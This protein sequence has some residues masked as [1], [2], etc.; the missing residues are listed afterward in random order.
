M[1]RLLTTVMV[2]ALLVVT[3]ATAAERI[4]LPDNYSIGYTF[5]GYVK[6]ADGWH[7][8][9]GVY[10]LV[11]YKE[12]I[13][14][15]YGYK[16]HWQIFYDFK[17][18]RAL[19]KL[20]YK[21]PTWRTQ[22]VELLRDQ[23][24]ANAFERAIGVLGVQFPSSSYYQKT[25]HYPTQFRK[26][27]VDLISTV[28]IDVLNQQIFKNIEGMQLTQAQASTERKEMFTQLLQLQAMRDMREGYER[29]LRAGQPAVSVEQG[30]IG[31]APIRALRG[32]V[33]PELLAIDKKYNCTGCHAKSNS[34]KWTPQLHM[35]LDNLGQKEVI[36]RL[37]SKGKDH[38]PR[39]TEKDE[40]APDLSTD[41]ILKFLVP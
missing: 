33:S 21:D 10:S 9:N 31:P 30:A 24:E 32:V 20:D 4:Y 11:E 12:W 3:S 16:G 41:E 13:A 34:A 17:F 29:M 2:I 36:D 6:H 14:G 1:K 15:S 40:K 38:M 5:N 27:A 23:S 37:V 19:P 18:V 7:F 26:E 35:T 22:Y 39:P 8:Q 25:N 28:N